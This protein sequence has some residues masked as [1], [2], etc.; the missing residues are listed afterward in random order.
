MHSV[1]LW[2]KTMT[3]SISRE[4]FGDLH[5]IVD[6]GT[7]R[8]G[9]NS[10]DRYLKALMACFD[11]IVQHPMMYPSVEM[12]KEGYR[13]CICQRET[14]YFRLIDDRVDI[15]RIIRWQAYTGE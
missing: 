10:A 15:V 7:Q 8:Y 14:I 13:K 1:N 5:N 11:R 12:V 9:K 3:Y 6:Y 2:M 4:A